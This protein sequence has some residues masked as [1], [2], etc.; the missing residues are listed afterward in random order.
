[1]KKGSSAYPKLLDRD[2]LYEQYWGKNLSQNDIANI[3]GCNRISVLNALRKYNI[4]SK[5]L[6][7]ASKTKHRELY[8][9]DWLFK[10]YQVEKLSSVQI[11]KIMGCT[12]NTVCTAL[13]EMKVGV[14]SISETKTGIKMSA[15][16]KQ[17]LS[18]TK[19]EQ[20]KKELKDKG[21][22]FEQYVKL[23]HSTWEIGADIGCS[24]QTV[25]NWL[26]YYSIPTREQRGKQTER[27]KE[28]QRTGEKGVCKNCGN[29]IYIP[30]PSVDHTGEFCNI[31]CYH[32][33]QRRNQITKICKD[34]GDTFTVPLSRNTELFCSRQC[35]YT[36]N[37]GEKSPLWKGGMDD[38]ICEVCGKKFKDYLSQRRWNHI[39]CSRSCARQ[40]KKIPKHHTLPERIFEE[41][42][43]KN[44][45]PFHF[46][47]DGQLWIGKKTKLNPD[48]IEANGKKICVE[49]MGRY[50]HSPLLN[51]NVARYA[52]LNY[53][54]MHY[55]KFKWQPVFIW[56]DDL[57]RGD[58]EQFVLST[59]KRE[60]VIK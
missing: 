39:T 2:W 47:G 18:N 5:T 26:E 56:E 34:C 9:Y 20:S 40:L 28:K 49:V 29:T 22:L 4:K 58:A 59:L 31:D 8:D 50:W 55:K 51:S 17:N 53:R 41:I 6:S 42:C 24:P 16:A 1:M 44:S 30:S 38:L 14:R 15:T 46:V 11:A 21:W 3:V 27:S 32:E 37:Q 13:S 60:G 57:K 7:E 19:R 33:W 52:N 35:A 10:K 43:K 25:L 12:P 23:G 48:F 54:E 36:H 45:I